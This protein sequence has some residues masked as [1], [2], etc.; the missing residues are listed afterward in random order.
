MRVSTS[1]AITLFCATA[2]TSPRAASAEPEPVQVRYSAPAGCS[3]REAFVRELALRTSR[4]RVLETPAAGATF[5]VELADRASG[6]VGQLRWLEPDGGETA[7]SVSGTTCEEVVSALAL[8][9]AVL[10]D[11]E[12]LTRSPT[13]P[14]PTVVTPPEPE[15]E[16]WS[17]RPS[18]GAGARVATAVGPGWAL[19]P[20]LE[21]GLESEQNGR[22][23]PALRLSFE[24]LA[25][26]TESTRAGDADFTTTFGRLSLCP[27]RFPSTGALFAAP[28]AGFELGE[29]HAEGTRTTGP[30]QVSLLWLAADPFLSLAYRPLRILSLE[31]EA[32]GVFPLVRGRFIFAPA[33]PVFSIP[34][35]GFSARA[36]LSVV[37]P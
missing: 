5:V 33:V 1:A 26:P 14:A 13:S 20:N 29:L 15:R 32:G 31:L 35:A 22:R 21:L 27:L 17:F 16:T 30:D 36:G 25:S 3:S 24:R 4:V 28:C 8:I 7:R 19:G 9:A 37:W 18:F 2:H 11:P 23:G 34:I 6:V 12:S 10:V